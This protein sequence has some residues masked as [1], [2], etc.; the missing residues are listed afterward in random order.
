MPTI[1]NG[2]MSKLSE[3]PPDLVA[4]RSNALGIGAS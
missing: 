4:S 1:I 3:L 2:K